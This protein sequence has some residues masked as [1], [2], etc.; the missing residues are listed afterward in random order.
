MGLRTGAARSYYL[1]DGLGSVVAVTDA[2]GNVTNS[3]TYDPYGLTTKT[4]SSG[5]VANPWRY[6][7]QYQDSA[8]GLYK[9]G[10]RYYQPELGRWS[11]QDPSGQE[12]NAYAGGKTVNFVDPSGL[13]TEFGD[14]FIFRYNN[15][16]GSCFGG[17][18]FEVIGSFIQPGASAVATRVSIVEA[19]QEAVQQAARKLLGR[20]LPAAAA[21]AIAC[22]AGVTFEEA[23]RAVLNRFDG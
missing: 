9:M 18:L 4:T 17:N 5:A 2:S 23:A 21:A 1:F 15:E 8:T 22:V 6:T 16:S 19:G 14:C 7:G 10:A 13:A 11:Q 12:A 20:S 3:Y